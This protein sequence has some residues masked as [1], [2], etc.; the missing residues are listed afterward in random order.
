MYPARK[1]PNVGHGLLTVVPSRCSMSD[2][3][4]SWDQ[5]WT[6]GPGL[7]LVRVSTLKPH[8]LRSQDTSQNLPKA[9]GLGVVSIAASGF[10]QKSQVSSCVWGR[11]GCVPLSCRW[12][13]A[14]LLFRTV[15]MSS[16]CSLKQN[17]LEACGNR[18]ARSRPQNFCFKRGWGGVG[19]S[20]HITS[21]QMLLLLILRT[22]GFEH[23]F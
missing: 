4:A 10:R 16:C 5:L 9:R 19:E 1:P 12:K 17:H 15:F 7:L 23:C 3:P 18:I 11:S 13:D 8:S 21:P 2:Q 20:E 6:W 22:T 14:A